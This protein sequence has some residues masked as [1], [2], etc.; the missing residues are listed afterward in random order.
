MTILQNLQ[1][2]PVFQKLR[3]F[4]QKRIARV[5]TKHK[6]R[7]ELIVSTFQ[8]VDDSIKANLK[9]KLQAQAQDIQEF[10]EIV[11]EIFDDDHKAE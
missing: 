4:E 11:S 7:K 3:T 8:Q 2:N 9:E 1:A 10:A 5:S 6:Q